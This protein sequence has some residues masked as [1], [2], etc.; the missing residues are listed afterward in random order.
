MNN[1]WGDICGQFWKLIT[2]PLRE[3]TLDFLSSLVHIVSKESVSLP[4]SVLG[5]HKPFVELPKLTTDVAPVIVDKDDP[6]MLIR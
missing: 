4:C 5:N 2:K 6:K 3:T 1:D